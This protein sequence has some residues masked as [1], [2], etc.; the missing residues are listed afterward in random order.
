MKTWKVYKIYAEDSNDI[1][2][3]IVPSP[4]KKEAENFVHNCSLNI[5]KTTEV[6]NFYLNVD[7]MINVLDKAGFTEDECD[8]VMR[9]INMVGF[10]VR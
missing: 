3:I 8:V 4:T 7:M 5:I 9:L 1:Y 6:E 2:R 10:G